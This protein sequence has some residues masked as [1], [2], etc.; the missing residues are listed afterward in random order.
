MTKIQTSEAQSVV[1][2]NAGTTCDAAC[3]V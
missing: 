3:Y 1:Q 2:R